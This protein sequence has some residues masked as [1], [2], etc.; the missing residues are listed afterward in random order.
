LG[1]KRKTRTRPIRRQPWHKAFEEDIVRTVLHDSIRDILRIGV[2]SK[3]D[4]LEVFCAKHSCS[5]SPQ[6]MNRWLKILDFD[7]IFHNIYRLDPPEDAP[8]PTQSPT[9]SPPRTRRARRA[10]TDP[11]ST[12]DIEGQGLLFDSEKPG[13]VAPEAR[14][15][16]QEGPLS[17][18]GAARRP[19]I[20]APAQVRE[21]ANTPPT[22]AIPPF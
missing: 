10:R 13:F 12:E 4:F 14:A 17:G 16:E 6:T 11:L 21:F 20:A 2:V 9:Q 3:K 15:Q 8:S 7:D 18:A 22:T 5:V 19:P 1:A